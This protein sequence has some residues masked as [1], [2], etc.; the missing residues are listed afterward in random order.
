MTAETLSWWNARSAP[1]IAARQERADRSRGDH[2]QPAVERRGLD[3]GPHGA[4]ALDE[5]SL[6]TDSSPR[7][8]LGAS[9]DGRC[10]PLDAGVLHAELGG[11]HDCAALPALDRDVPGPPFV[12]PSRTIPLRLPVR[13]L[14]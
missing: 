8:E 14:P 6:L 11:Q 12:R 1:L 5:R 3:A 4:A 7:G 13:G 2:R 9:A 10:V